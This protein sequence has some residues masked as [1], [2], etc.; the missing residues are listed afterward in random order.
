MINDED[1]RLALGVVT[2]TELQE[3]LTYHRERQKERAVSAARQ[4]RPLSS[5]ITALRRVPLRTAQP[6][7]QHTPSS[8]LPSVN[9][10]PEPL[11]VVVQVD[12]HAAA[13]VAPV[14][15]GTDTTTPS[16]GDTFLA[17]TTRSGAMEGSVHVALST[18]TQS[19]NTMTPVSLPV[20]ITAA[21][22]TVQSAG[23]DMGAAAATLNEPVAV[24]ASSDWSERDEG[25]VKIRCDPSVF[26]YEAM[27]LR[28]VRTH[29]LVIT[30]VVQRELMASRPSTC[31]LC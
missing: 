1:S 4:S 18:P 20:T 7:P 11:P 29:S 23:Q 27:P 13:E 21:V 24:R 22:D 30:S 14:P 6:S 5:I 31:L 28:E 10:R 19:S 26:L 17:D 25:K 15:T 3:L 16:L 2:R 12:T 8:A 9:S